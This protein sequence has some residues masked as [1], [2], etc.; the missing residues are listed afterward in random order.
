M[1]FLNIL[2][3]T[4]SAGLRLLILFFLLRVVL[5]IFFM[6]E[7]NRFSAFLFGVTEPF[8]LPF[9]VLFERLGWFQNIPLDV[10]FLVSSMIITILS[11]F[12]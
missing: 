6:G 9:R 1:V 7:E 4:V 2:C 10:P 3:A 12:L 8:V 5:D 11:L